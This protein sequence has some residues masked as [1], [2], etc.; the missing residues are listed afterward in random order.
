MLFG[1]PVEEPCFTDRRAR[2]TENKGHKESFIVSFAK[3][4]SFTLVSASN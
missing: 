2:L 4:T 1:H 3:H